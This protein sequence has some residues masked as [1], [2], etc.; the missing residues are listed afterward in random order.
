MDS[1]PA[2]QD[3]QPAHPEPTQRG[4]GGLYINFSI[5]GKTRRAKLFLKEREDWRKPPPFVFF[6]NLEN[7]KSSKVKI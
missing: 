3:G 7:W 4:T 2:P 1:L 5:R 6:E